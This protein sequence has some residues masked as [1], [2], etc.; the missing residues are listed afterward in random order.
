MNPTTWVYVS[1]LMIIGIYFK[2]HRVLSVRNLDLIALMAFSPGL[3]IIARGNEHWGYVWLF[4]VGG[5]FL[6]RLLLD[7]LMVR[8]PLLEPNLSASGLTFTGVALLFFLMANVI[9]GK[10]PDR[11]LRATSELVGP[12]ADRSAANH[13]I[14]P[15]EPYLRL[16]GFRPFHEFAE[17]DE[18]TTALDG[19]PLTA[20]QLSFRRVVTRTAAILGH[21]AVVIGIVLVGYRHFDNTHTGVAAASLYL[22][23]PYTAQLTREVDHVVPGAVLVWSIES[24]RRPV[25]AGLLFGLAAGLIFYPLFLLPLW[26]GFYWRRGLLRFLASTAVM[27]AI[28]VLALG[29][30]SDSLGE[31]AGQARQMFGWTSLWGEY[32]SGFWE[33]HRHAYRIPI[34]AAFLVLCGSLALW[35]PQKNLGTLLS[36][37]AA[38]MLAVQF[39]SPYQGGLYMAWYLPFLML[40][41]FRPNLED[42]VAV[43][44]VVEGRV[45]WPI[46]RLV[47]WAPRAAPAG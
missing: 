3:L 24:Y 20:R 32:A 47:R 6:V 8:R 44:A 43:T 45:P 4:S 30:T 16:P 10:V 46:R 36:L 12:L 9:I 35:P 42:R 1:S 14:Q 34:M 23:L 17:L 26:C 13:G 40:T 11:N 7:P 41:I 25:W 33:Y 18:Q 29:M 2:F 31:F 19:A 5:F 39:W 27:L 15:G 21:L 28:L 37:S 22:L 38:V